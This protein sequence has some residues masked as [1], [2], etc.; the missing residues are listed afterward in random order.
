LDR[1]FKG[2]EY[3]SPSISVLLS[4]YNGARWL[5]DAIKSVLNQTFKDFEFLLVDDGSTDNSLEIINI[6]AK[7]DPRIVV[8]SKINTG[9]ADSLNVGI[10]Q[11]RGE[12]IARLDADDISEPTRLEKQLEF[13]QK[14]PEVVLLGTG[15]M[16]INEKGIPVKS[17][18]YPGDHSSLLKKLYTSGKFPAHSSAF[19]RTSVVR[20]IGGYRPRIRRAQDRDLWLRLS[21]VGQLAS[22][23][24]P[25]VKIRRH[26]EQVSHEAA[27]RRQKTD[28]RVAIISYWLRCFDSSDPVSADNLVFNSFYSWVAERLEQVG[29]FHY[30]DYKK[31]LLESLIKNRFSPSTWILLF[32]LV[33]KNP[34]LTLRIFQFRIFGETISRRIALEW[35]K[36]DNS[37]Q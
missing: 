11:A 19:F 16:L 36:R 6:F 23:D 32:K 35:I 33:S 1:D 9:L 34:L 24:E 15:L 22:I 31:K 3:D 25:L 10:Q 12:W 8:I 29:L 14:N 27:G 17:F 4:C 5:D 20:S 18:R 21:E 28:S 30:F 13:V 2:L 37:F 26:S 7:I